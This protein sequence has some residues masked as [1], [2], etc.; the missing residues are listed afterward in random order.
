MPCLIK[1]RWFFSLSVNLILSRQSQSNVQAALEEAKA[2]AAKAEEEA[3]RAAK[4][5]KAAVQPVATDV[6]AERPAKAPGSGNKLLGSE[7]HG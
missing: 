1:I 5:T 2:Q 7:K 6:T 4:T 3:K